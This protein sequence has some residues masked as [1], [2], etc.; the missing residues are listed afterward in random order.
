MD[1]NRLYDPTGEIDFYARQRR[2]RL[3]AEQNDV[4]LD[5]VILLLYGVLML[6]AGIV[7]DRLFLSWG[8]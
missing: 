2:E 4:N 8:L 5:A 3:K 1:E 6:A 7:A